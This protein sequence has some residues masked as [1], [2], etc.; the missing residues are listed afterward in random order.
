[1]PKYKSIKEAFNAARLL[2][3]FV[4]QINVYKSIV[5]KSSNAT[6]VYQDYC[7]DIPSIEEDMGLISDTLLKLK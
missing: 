6:V 4:F 7:H 3:D 2:N 5:D 1:M